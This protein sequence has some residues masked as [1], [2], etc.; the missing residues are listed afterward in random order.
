MTEEIRK[1]IPQNCKFQSRMLPDFAECKYRIPGQCVLDVPG[2]P[3]SYGGGYFC[4][5][6][7][8]KKHLDEDRKV[9]STGS[10]EV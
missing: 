5:M 8:V 9:Y 1:F 10:K 7:K 4:F 3:M 6:D 2:H